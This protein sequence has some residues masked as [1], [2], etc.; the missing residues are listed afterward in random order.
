M[1]Q[2]RFIEAT[3]VWMFRDN[4]P[5]SAAQ[6]FVARSIFPPTPQTMQGIVRTAYLEGQGVDW[7]RYNNGQERPEL[8]DAVGDATSLGNLQ[9]NGPFLARCTNGRVERLVPAP[10]DLLQQ[11]PGISGL[12]RDALRYQS[13]APA[14]ELTFQTSV[15][16]EGWRPVMRPVTR[17]DEG[18]RFG[19]LEDG[20]L[21]EA[22]FSAYLNGR[23]D[24][25]DGEVRKSSDL[26]ESEE[27]P[28]LA[29]DY[30]RR[31]ARE[32]H[33]Y[34]AQFIRPKE[35]VGLLVGTNFDALPDDG[36]LRMGGESRMGR[37]RKVDY[38]PPQVAQRGRV[39]IVLLTPAWFDGGWG[40]ANG[41]WSPWVGAGRLVSY[42]VGKPQALSGWNM[43]AG[44]PKPLRHFVP[45]GSVYYF[46]DA[47]L[48]GLPFTQSLPDEAD[49]GAMGFGAWAAGIWNYLA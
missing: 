35:N 6:N 43:A 28:G 27:R 16:F 15:P 40:P 12:R 2:W 49:Y 20:W 36:V 29:L 9:L 30:G 37:C 38:Q 18:Q 5:F 7:K 47:E 14:R 24:E 34:R 13:M 39:R 8:Y 21:N 42:V 22:Q 1:M 33:Y 17:E 32:S 44:Q 31:A 41:D 3:D 10:R 48:S 19:E 45:A 46:E 26:F 11:K 25:V 23:A 4:K